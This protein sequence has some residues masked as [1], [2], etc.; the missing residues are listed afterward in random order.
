M[1]CN[2][3]NVIVQR[4]FR[5]ITPAIMLVLMTSPYLLVRLLRM[6]SNDKYDLRRAGAIGVGLLFV[7][8][9]VGHFIQTESMAQMLP[10]W[11]PQRVLIVYV[12]GV[13]EFIIA[14]GFFL[15]AHRR[16]SG[17]FAAI[18]LIV[19]FPANIYA[20]INHVPM[21]GHA[22]GPSYLLIRAPLQLAILMWVYWFTIRRADIE[23]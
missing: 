3:N 22:W 21:G 14:I 11:M 12:T 19:F 15:P 10:S 13:L 16:V 5:M 23:N 9:G 4:D 1:I 7:F 6:I 2:W 17:W 8:T 20:A 18:V